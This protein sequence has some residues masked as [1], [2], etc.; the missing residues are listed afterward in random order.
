MSLLPV[1]TWLASACAAFLVACGWIDIEPALVSQARE[2][3]FG[4]RFTSGRLAKQPWRPCRATDTTLLV[5]RSQCSEPI[6]ASTPGLDAYRRG[7]LAVRREQVRDSSVATLYAMALLNLRAQDSRSALDRAV[8]SL[9]QARAQA[10][11]DAG[12]LNDLAVAYL[13]VGER[14]QA[15]MPMLRAL[16]VVD[17]ALARDSTYGPARFNRALILQRLFLA[18]SAAHAWSA[19]IA[20]ERDEEWKSEAQVHLRELAQSQDSLAPRFFSQ[21]ARQR[22]FALL[23][24]WGEAVNTGNRARADSQLAR[25]TALRDSLGNAPDQSVAMTLDWLRPRATNPLIAPRIGTAFVDLAKGIALHDSARYAAGEM[26]LVRADESL[27]ALKSPAAGWAAF[28]RAACE[29]NLG[30]PG[31]AAKRLERTLA[32]AT[33]REPALIGKATWVRGVIQLRQGNYERAH[34]LYQKARSLFVRAGDAPNEAAVSYLLTESL[35]FAGQ[36]LTSEAE[37]YMGLRGLA[38]FRSSQY[39]K[40]LLIAVAAHARDAGL[41]LAVLDVLSEALVVDEAFPVPHQIA[42]TR[43]TRAEDLAV[44]GDTTKAFAE[45]DTAAAAAALGSGMPAARAMA[46]VDLARGRLLMRR[47]PDGS[48]RS[49]DRAVDGYR[50]INVVNVLPA[51]LFQSALLATSAGDKERARSALAE[52]IS[53]IERRREAFASAE[54]Q[55]AY[56]ETVESVFDLAIGIE[57]DALNTDAAFDLLERERIAIRPEARS[58][59]GVPLM[60]LASL[61][62]SIPHDMLFVTYAVLGDRVGIWYAYNGTRSYKQSLVGRDTIAR[63]AKEAISEIRESKTPQAGARLFEILLRPIASELRRARSLAAVPDRELLSVPLAALWDSASKHYLVEDVAILTEPSASFMVAA[64][65]AARTR[66][67]ATSALVVGNPAGLTSSD[68]SL[69]DLPGAEVEAKRV[70]ALYSDHLVLAGPAANPRSVIESLSHRTI[71]HFAGHAVFD[72]NRPER[73]Y[74]ALS[75]SGQ[76]GSGRLEAREIAH[77]NLSNTEIVVLSAC[78]TLP[79]KPSRSGA[80]AG[81]AVSFLRAGAPAIVSTLWDIADDGATDV[82]V[83]FH[84]GLR[85]GVEPAEALRD[86][87][88]AALRS[89]PGPRGAAGAWAAFVYTGPWTINRGSD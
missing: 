22:F 61:S 78:R 9:E 63:L 28:Y 31:S 23:G 53:V 49:L 45:L 14:D 81:I 5:P 84:R 83:A 1:R 30:R 73:S 7:V 32:E 44:V 86:A 36:P 67:A 25:A 56:Y 72:A 87:Q 52:A 48:R 66:G 69:A 75:D 24:A 88:K 58:G 21:R 76:S 16:D 38:P 40:N 79:A 80:V 29:A 64:S 18:G 39:L 27:R 2:A 55:A 8:A 15:L 85:D 59:T 6:A 65:R 71:F 13:A 37:A 74:L 77:L 68:T 33:D 43:W 70:A 62:Q 35:A 17:A 57:L 46:D 20:G 3:T 50:G 10:P 12:I 47:D 82:V 60:S 89:K 54:S 51:A 26:N 41:R 11:N 42:Y 19:Y 4:V 34:D